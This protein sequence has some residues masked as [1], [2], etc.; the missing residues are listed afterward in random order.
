MSRNSRRKSDPLPHGAV[1]PASRLGMLAAIFC[2][3]AL[4]A[5]T[6]AA[7]PRA[8]A[9]LPPPAYTVMPESVP[10]NKVS[11]NNVP[12]S[13]VSDQ[14][15][16]ARL[17]G[18]QQRCAECHSEVVESFATTPHSRTLRR[19]IDESVL[20]KFAGQSYTNPR[21]HSTFSFEVR[22]GRLWVSPSSYGRDL[23]V[24][25]I[26]GSGTHAL[27]PLVMFPVEGLGIRPL[28]LGVSWYPGRGLDA[29]LDRENPDAA[30]LASLGAFHMTTELAAC[31]GCHSTRLPLDAQQ[32]IRFDL[33]EPNL[34]CA[35]CHF[36]AD[37]HEREQLDN[38]QGA[39]ENLTQLSPLD[40]VNRCGECHR[41]AAEQDPAAIREHDPSI[42]RFASVGLVQSPCFL[43][44]AEV[45]LE[46][47]VPA[48]MDCVTCHDPHRPASKDWRHY[49]ASCLKCHDAAHGRSKDCPVAAR[50]DNCLTCHMPPR[51]VNPYLSFTD[52]WI[53][54]RT[55][56][57]TENATGKATDQ[58]AGQAT[59][60]AAS[61][62]ANP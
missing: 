15:A 6:V 13:A 54:V 23:P 8:Q 55:D 18:T 51:Q 48:R 61:A 58:A 35:R 42:D 57:A 31:F 33:I 11:A 5:G 50:E 36:D 29:T 32:Q 26:F 46:G 40:A 53:R 34:G 59:E 30:G 10:A 52:H 47:N 60:S 22:D 24:D 62:P 7:R 41:R 25:W 39:I 43:R 9:I 17:E 21:N 4:V 44:Q 2:L 37:R 56:L 27:T 3:A 28:E 14:T 20:G 49:T 12:E 1:P 38:G 45:T 16:P 19:A